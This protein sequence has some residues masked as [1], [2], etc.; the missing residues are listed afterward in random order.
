MN[1]GR[2]LNAILDH[3][4]D[5]LRR[6]LDGLSHE[7]LLQQPSGPGS[8]PIGWLTWH[9]SRTR[10]TSISNLMQVEQ[11]WVAG[12]WHAKFGFAATDLQFSRVTPEQVQSFDP[13]AVDVLLGYYGAVDAR[14]RAY[15]QT[16]TLEDLE[17]PPPPRPDHSSDTVAEALA[18]TW[19]DNLQHIG[20]IAYLRGLIRGHGW[21]GR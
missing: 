7:E 12:G 9:L 2:A 21:Y 6:A 15:L 18:R 19:S 14:A 11:M 16:L 4:D 3:A 17:R 1:A 10:D 5:V 8:N 13:V 20:Q